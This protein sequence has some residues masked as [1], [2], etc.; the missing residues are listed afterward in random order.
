MRMSLVEGAVRW[1]VRRLREVAFHSFRGSEEAATLGRP[2][3]ITMSLQHERPRPMLQ[4]QANG[5]TSVSESCGN[6]NCPTHGNGPEAVARRLAMAE[7]KTNEELMSVVRLLAGNA[8][9]QVQRRAQDAGVRITQMETDIINS[10]FGGEYDGDAIVTGIV[11][12]FATL[13]KGSHEP[14]KIFL[15]E[16]GKA[17]APYVIDRLN[18]AEKEKD[19]IRRKPPGFQVIEMTF[20]DLMEML[21]GRR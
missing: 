16:C 15:T 14:T 6:P 4:G 10:I 9:F 8:H 19:G 5:R 2:K 21:S 20:E 17:Q 11:E 7:I 13:M 12:G 1:M 18:E 3:R